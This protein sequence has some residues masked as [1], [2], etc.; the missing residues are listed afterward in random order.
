MAQIEQGLGL[1]GIDVGQDNDGGGDSEL[2]SVG[3]PVV[4][5]SDRG[6][7]G[8]WKGLVKAMV[9]AKRSILSSC[10]CTA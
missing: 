10:S 8:V 2:N 5:G 7:D 1:T 9:V 6:A 3:A 4:S